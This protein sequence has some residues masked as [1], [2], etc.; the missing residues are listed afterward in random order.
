[1]AHNSILTAKCPVST[2]DAY[3]DRIITCSPIFDPDSWVLKEKR[4]L[5]VLLLSPRV[6]LGTTAS[7]VQWA[8]VKR[9]LVRYIKEFVS[10]G[11]QIVAMCPLR[12]RLIT[13]CEEYVG[14]SH[15]N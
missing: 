7:V 5:E 8:N 4:D 10:A 3:N 14:S 9:P 15:V 11:L 2:C 6:H 13:R 1:M 12:R